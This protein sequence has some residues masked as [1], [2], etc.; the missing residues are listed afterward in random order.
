MLAPRTR[1]AIT[2]RKNIGSSPAVPAERTLSAPRGGREHAEDRDALR[3]DTAGG[4][5]GEQ[6]QAEQAHERDE[7]EGRVSAVPEPG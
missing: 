6:D 3:V 1:P 2:R 5:L 4:E 7:D